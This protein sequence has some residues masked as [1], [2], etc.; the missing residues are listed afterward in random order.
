[1]FAGFWVIEAE[2]CRVQEESSQLL[3]G[4]FYLVICDGIV[5]AFVVNGIA[6]DGVIY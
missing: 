6:D 2:F 5:A 3:Y 4:F 1:M